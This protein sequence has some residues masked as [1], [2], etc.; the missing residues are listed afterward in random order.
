MTIPEYNTPFPLFDQWFAEAQQDEEIEDATAMFLA[1]CSPEGQPSVRAVLLKKHDPQGFVFYTNLKS[2]KGQE[3]LNN[4]KASLAFYWPS[5]GRQ[6]RIAGEVEPVSEQ[7][8]DEYFASR[9]WKSRIGAWA[10][11]QSQIM[12][13]KWQLEKRVAKYSTRFFLRKVPRP[14][15]WSGFRLKPI[16]ME[17]WLEGP[18]RLHERLLYQKTDDNTWSKER[19]F[20]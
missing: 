7:E 5:Q 13:D 9:A 3:L 18:F 6:I 12:K 15:H 2:Q 14:P 17:F 4:P 8:A 16:S 19:L 20:P 10:S 11:K 1:T